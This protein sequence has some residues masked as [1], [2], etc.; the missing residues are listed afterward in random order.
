[1]AGVCDSAKWRN[2]SESLKERGNKGK[3]KTDIN[4]NDQHGDNVHEKVFC[5]ISETGLIRVLLDKI[6]NTE[7]LH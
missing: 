4:V 7:V 1:M 6:N 5:Q 2:V 3:E